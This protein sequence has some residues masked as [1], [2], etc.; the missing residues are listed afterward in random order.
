MPSLNQSLYIEESVQSILDQNY[1][2]LDLLILDGGTTD[3]GQEIINR[4][5]NHL[6]YWQSRSDGGQT[7]T[8]VQGFSRAT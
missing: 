7:D 2:N 5:S 8:L 1:P 3:G 6:A 4:Y